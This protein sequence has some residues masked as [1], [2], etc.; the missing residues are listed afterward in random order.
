MSASRSP[1]KCRPGTKALSRGR[2]RSSGRAG[3]HSG[4]GPVAVRRGRSDEAGLGQG[5][6]GLATID[7]PREIE[8]LTEVR[9]KV[10]SMP[11]S[12]VAACLTACPIYNYQD[13]LAVDG[14]GARR[15]RRQLDR[16]ADGR[17]HAV[18]APDNPRFRAPLLRQGARLPPLVGGGRAREDQ[19]L[20]VASDRIS[21]PSTSSSSPRSPT[22]SGPHP[23]LPV[24]VSAARRGRAQPC[25]RPTCRRR[26]LVG[27][28]SFDGWRCCPSSAWPRAYLT[29]GGLREYA[30]DGHVRRHP[31]RRVSSSGSRF[32]QPIFARPPRAPRG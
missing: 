14:P 4:R 29:G 23:T 22:R 28:S 16:A 25:C 31:P 11:A 3:P 13:E 7:S 2:G 17:D 12:V 15:L 10:T 27:R 5:L 30:A 20:L 18:R 8:A 32:E 1:R 21:R 6:A 9:D 24:V 26:L 19:L